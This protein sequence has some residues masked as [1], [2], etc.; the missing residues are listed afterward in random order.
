MQLPGGNRGT[1]LVHHHRTGPV[2]LPGGQ[3]VPRLVPSTKRRQHAA[4]VRCWRGG[5]SNRLG[6]FMTDPAGIAA[7]T[8]AIRPFTASR[9]AMLRQ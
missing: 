3:L 2:L 5:R 9:R 7:L 1:G 4:A 8:E 6:A